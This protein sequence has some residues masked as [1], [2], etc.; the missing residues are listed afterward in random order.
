M[1]NP[2]VIT[3]VL[4]LH[5]P[6]EM[7]EGVCEYVS[8]KVDHGFFEP[9]PVM[10]D[11]G[12]RVMLEKRACYMVMADTSFELGYHLNSVALEFAKQHSLIRDNQT[13]SPVQSLFLFNPIGGG[14]PVHTDSGTGPLGRQIIS[15]SYF[16]DSFDGGELVFPDIGVTIKPKIG[17]TVFFA[18]NNP[19]RVNPLLSGQRVSL[20]R[21]YAI[22]T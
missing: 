8:D 12:P 11:A 4:R 6:H 10:T 22:H 9:Q 2:P 16:N 13:L 17:L 5:L 18:A 21:G 1:I 19:H 3:D 15:M 14:I 7:V 20:Q